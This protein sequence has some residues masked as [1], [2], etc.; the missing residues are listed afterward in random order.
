MKIFSV[1]GARPNF[2]KVAPIHRAFQRYADWIQHF[3]VHTGQ[4][5]S[6]EMSA[7]FFADVGMP[8]PTVHLNV[9]SGSH[10]EQTARAMME[11]ENTFQQH[12]PDLVIVVGDV[13]S[14]LAGAIAAAK[15]GI[16][17]AH[18]EAGLRSFDRAMPEEINRIATDAV[19]DY[20]FVTEP[21]ALTNLHREGW[22]DSRIFLV[23]NTLIDSLYFMLPRARESKIIEKFKLK[24]QY[25]VVTLHRP[26]N[27][28]NCTQLEGLLRVFAELSET[29][30]VVFPIHPRTR[31]NIADFGLTHIAE[32]A[33]RLFV[34]DP[35]GYVD[36]LALTMRADFVLTDSGGIQEETTVLGIPCL[37]LR[38]TTERPITCEIGTN[39]LVPPE[40]A[41]VRSAI[42][43]VLN[44]P[45]KESHIPPLWDG[46][47]AE[48]IAQIIAEKLFCL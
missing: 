43:Q 23:G 46:K 3:I 21:S 27:V 44:V 26:N 25:V 11:L 13:N 4:H 22:D 10:A 28:G 47:A 2:V 29:L 42:A 33:P 39:Q 7:L 37:T 31:N 19:A 36:F 12:K 17:L 35:L 24:E 45:R 18:V 1:V 30:D 48:R 5:Y 40:P 34:I 38:T 6:A 32:P 14:T 8:T 16:P 41:R 15:C 9:G 20:A